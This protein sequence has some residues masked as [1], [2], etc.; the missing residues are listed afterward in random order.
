[1][2]A[3]EQR[4]Q[5]GL[6]MEY[7][8]SIFKLVKEYVVPHR[9]KEFHARA[10]AMAGGRLSRPTRKEQMA[11]M[12]CDDEL[13]EFEMLAEHDDGALLKSC[14][15]WGSRYFYVD[16][17]IAMKLA[18]VPSSP[19]LDMVREP[20]F[21]EVLSD[22]VNRE[23]VE[24]AMIDA[25]RKA[26][27]TTAYINT[28]PDAAFAIIL[29]GGEKDEDGKTTPRSLRK[30]PHHDGLV[31]N[32]NDDDSVDRPHLN[33]ALAR[34]DQTDLSA[35]DKTKARKH[36][37]GHRDRLAKKNE[38]KTITAKFGILQKQE[39]K[40]VVTGVVLEPDVVMALAADGCVDVI[41]ADEIERAA[42]KFLEDYRTIKT[43]H[44]TSA[45][46]VSVVESY[47]APADFEIDGEKILKGSWIMS[48]HVADS[49]MWKSIED[50]E[51]DG[52]SVGGFTDRIIEFVK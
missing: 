21:D 46:A 26:E 51:Y 12:L 29:P 23:N 39:K 25:L 45:P 22:A 6:T 33:N 4:G 38:E 8:E 28:L 27:W 13:A 34:L 44:Q 50:G 35:K 32:P 52:F 41:G 47:I 43:N 18:F 24:V 15:V 30:L 37:E 10:R 16:D 19:A 14:D 31:E 20:V 42:W 11:L 9:W 49:R 48:V 5:N 36:L 40:Q 7:L 3:S 17:S 2:P 1:M